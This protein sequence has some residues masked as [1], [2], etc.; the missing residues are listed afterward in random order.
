MRGFLQS[1]D[2]PH[3]RRRG[4]FQ[5]LMTIAL[6]SGDHIGRRLARHSFCIMITF[7]HREDATFIDEI[8]DHE[9]HTHKELK[10]HLMQTK[11]TL[12]LMQRLSL[13]AS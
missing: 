10:L 5:I 12:A 8:N 1:D 11:T 2:K 7:V 6:P 13:P 4:K 3:A 9:T